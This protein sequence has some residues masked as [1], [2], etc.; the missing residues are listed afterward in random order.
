MR[1][2]RAGILVS[3]NEAAAQDAVQDVFIH[4]YQRIRHFG[5]CQTFEPYLLKHVVHATLNLARRDRKFTSHDGGL[6]LLSG[7]AYA[8]GRSLGYI[9][10]TGIV[11]QGAPIR[12]LAEPV[13]LTRDG[14]TL[15]I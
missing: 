7:V 13:S 3:Q 12:V 4:I 9:P 6:A 2:A 8:I 11:E 10:G 1:E 5:E 14:I 15:T